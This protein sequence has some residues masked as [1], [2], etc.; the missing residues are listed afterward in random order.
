MTDSTDSQAPLSSPA[1]DPGRPKGSLIRTMIGNLSVATAT[2][3]LGSIAT[4]VGW[5]PPRGNWM[6]KVA[7]IWSHVTL[8][9]SGVRL[10]VEFEEEL[11]PNR[12]YVYM[13]NHQSMYDIP[14]LIG[15]M[16]GQVR[17][18]AKKSL[19]RIPV[20]GWAL[21]SGGFIPVDRGNRRAAAETYRI[22]VD[23][24][25]KGRS[26]LIFPEQTRSPD[27]NLLPFKRGGVVIAQQTGALVVP[28]GIRGT[29]DIRPKGSSVIVP[30]EVKVVYG[31]PMTIPAGT[32]DEPVDQKEQIARTRVEVERLLA[33]S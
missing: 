4:L 9:V 7:Q 6:Y 10:K 18:M 28:V 21:W 12:G 30:G 27:G 5:I 29:R 16:P 13:A 3:V 2:F 11:D 26:I 1:T 22:A 17:F 20:F 25:S 8:F 32:E 24:I 23:Y 15:S 19:F 14:A 31:K 33:K